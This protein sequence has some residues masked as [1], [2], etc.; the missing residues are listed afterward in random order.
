MTSS[1][2]SRLE[3]IPG[4]A[5][6]AVDL[7]ETGG[8][9]NVRLEPGANETAVMERLRSVLV[10]YGVRPPSP[11][12]PSVE[13]QS[14]TNR[15]TRGVE[16]AITPI[17]TGARV[18]VSTSNVRSFRVVT[19]TPAAIAQGVADAW[20]QVVGQIPVEITDAKVDDQGVLHIEAVDGE[21]RSVASANVALGWERALIEVIGDAL[22]ALRGDQFHPPL[23][24]NA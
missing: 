12:K 22:E 24:V 15:K 1:L 23:V 3:D 4:V 21:R 10:A 18:E 20:C 17:A 7:T 6:V 16:V 8:G 2:S 13:T 5:S 9:I 19:A 11:P 14:E